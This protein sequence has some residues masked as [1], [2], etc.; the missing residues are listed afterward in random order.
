LTDHQ[1]QVGFCELNQSEPAE[2]LDKE[3][4]KKLKSKKKSSLSE[5]ERWREV[6]KVLFP[7]DDEETIPS[8]CE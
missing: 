8:P 7:N 6:Y 1:R 4:E 5:E 2:G 3:Q